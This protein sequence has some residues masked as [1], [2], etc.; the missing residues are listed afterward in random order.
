[1]AT[2]PALFEKAAAILSEGYRGGAIG[3]STVRDLYYQVDMMRR[4]HVRRYLE[5]RKARGV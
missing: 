5:E 4:R 2:D 1:M 3:A